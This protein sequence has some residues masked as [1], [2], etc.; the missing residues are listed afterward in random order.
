MKGATVKSI[1]LRIAL[2]VSVLIWLLCLLYIAQFF[3]SNRL[4]LTG[5]E[6]QALT[7]SQ[8]WEMLTTLL[9]IC[10]APY[11]LA[12]YMMDLMPARKRYIPL[13]CLWVYLLITVP[14]RGT[15]GPFSTYITNEDHLFAL[16]H[17][18][19]AILLAAKFVCCLANTRP[20]KSDGPV[21]TNSPTMSD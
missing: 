6:V 2:I 17:L 10:A 3:E 14:T 1:W 20:G 18:I 15:T 12:S 16:V 7:P 13:I 4:P 5:E 19:S 9:F 8:I 11:L 21:G